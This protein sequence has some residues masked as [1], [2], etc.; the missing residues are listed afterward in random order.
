[1]KMTEGEYVWND[2]WNNDE[3]MKMTMKTMYDNENQ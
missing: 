2:F 3:T 1:M